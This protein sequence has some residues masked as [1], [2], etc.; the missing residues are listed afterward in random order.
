LI[1]EASL[2]GRA[3]LLPTSRDKK[4]GGEGAGSSRMRISGVMSIP[5][6]S[7]MAP[8]SAAN[9]LFFLEKKLGELGLMSSSSYK[10]NDVTSTLTSSLG[11]SFMFL[12]SSSYPTRASKVPSRVP[13]IPSP[14]ST[15]QP[16]R[17]TLP[18][19]TKNKELINQSNRRPVSNKER[20]VIT[21]K[22]IESGTEKVIQITG[23]YGGIKNRVNGPMGNNPR[24][25]TNT[26]GNKT[27]LTG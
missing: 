3:L 13:S 24:P 9:D 16:V 26:A 27:V 4:R 17:K 8:S 6:A 1:G 2:S 7:N 20:T 14:L 18:A 22:P 23:P 25:P 19:S 12:S 21:N 5:K 15:T 10:N 11:E